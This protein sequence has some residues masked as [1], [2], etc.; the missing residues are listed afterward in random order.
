MNPTRN[1]AA[2]ALGLTEL[3]A[4]TILGRTR[5]VRAL[6][7]S[8]NKKQLI[9]ARDAEGTTPLMAAVLT[10][11]LTIAK[12]LLRNLAS[13][14]ARDQKGYRAL[15]HAKARLFKNKL[16]VYHRLGLPPIPTKQCRQRLAIAKILRYPV[17]R[18]SRSVAMISMLGKSLSSC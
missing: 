15:E 8:D 6:L 7:A 5:R 13:S 12:L 9:E 18:R 17:A 2:K 4:A 1:S 3:H 14:K 16:S 10:G 11:R